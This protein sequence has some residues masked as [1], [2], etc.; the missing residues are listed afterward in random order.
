MVHLDF[1][2][3]SISFLRAICSVSV[4]P[5]R[6]NASVH[7]TDTDRDLVS[8]VEGE[9][10]MSTKINAAIV[11]ASLT[12]LAAPQ[13]ASAQGFGNYA[14]AVGDTAAVQNIRPGYLT[15]LPSDARASVGTV[16]RHRVYI[17]SD[18]RG[19]V[20]PFGAFGGPESPTYAPDA[21]APR[22]YDNSGTPDFQDG[23]RG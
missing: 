18:A 16:K 23:S 1:A 12:L 11:A 14:A 2:E 17:P 7:G 9:F 20:A 13:I 8:N 21:P 6:Q 10:T 15:Q 5:P 4:Y 3:L 19:A 22:S